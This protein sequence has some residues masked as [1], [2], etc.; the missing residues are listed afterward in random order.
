[1][2]W[3]EK[4]FCTTS[5]CS[6]HFT[7]FD[8]NNNNP[9]QEIE[10][11]HNEPNVRGKSTCV[12]I[13]VYFTTVVSNHIL[14]VTTFYTFVAIKALLSHFVRN[15]VYLPLEIHFEHLS[16]ATFRSPHVA[17]GDNVGQRSS[18]YYETDNVKSNCNC[19]W[20]NQFC[21]KLVNDDKR[22]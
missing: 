17:N 16:V 8:N 1:M 4:L 9:T 22:N 15:E 7:F 12:R 3:R 18:M 11:I 5:F 20:K 19:D 13:V 21:N 6:I 2:S 10:P 14:S